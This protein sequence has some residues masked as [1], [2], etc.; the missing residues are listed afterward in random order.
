[1]NIKEFAEKACNEIAKV[2]RKEVTCKEVDKLN[3]AKRYGLM[4]LEP[5]GN[6]APTLYLDEFYHMYLH[7]ENWQ[8]TLNQIIVTYLSDSFPSSIDMEWFKDFGRVQELIF[9]KLINFDANTALLEQVP[10]TRYLDF[11]IVYCVHYENK[12]FGSGSILIH[13]SHLTMWHCTTQDLAR[14]AEANTPRLYPLFVSTLENALT[15]LGCQTDNKEVL[16]TPMYMMSNKTSTNGAISIYYKDSL[17]TLANMLDSDVVILPSSVHEVLL[18]PLRG[19]DNFRELKDM[20][21]EVNHTCLSEEEF[22]SD[23]IYLYRRN[24]D[25]I[26]II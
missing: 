6:I 24:T 19:N 9:Y 15:K 13:N 4:I 17:K 14:L 26:E 21:Y 3:G 7:T 25:D 2:L 11:A 10:H 16:N 5:G 1:M 8:E 12:E 23:N 18:L 22:L 20:V